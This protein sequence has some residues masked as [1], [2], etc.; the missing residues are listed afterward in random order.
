MSVFFVFRNEIYAGVILRNDI[1]TVYYDESGL[2]VINYGYKKGV[3][4]G[5]HINPLAVGDA[6]EKYYFQ[7]VGGNATA[8]PLLMNVISWLMNNCRTATVAIHNE[9]KQVCQWVYNFSIWNIPAGWT[10]SM[11]DAQILHVFAL[12]YSY[13]KNDTYLSIS[14]RII[15]GFEIPIY[16]G[17]NRLVLD[18][19]T[20]WYPEVIVAPDIDSS[21]VTPLILNG[22]LYALEDLFLSYLLLNQSRVQDIF[23]TGIASARA[24][25]HKYELPRNWTYYKLHPQAIASEQYHRVHVK[26]TEILYDITNDSL[27]YTYHLRWSNFTKYPEP[28]LSEMLNTAGRYL[29]YGSLVLLLAF[30]SILSL[31]VLQITVRRRLKRRRLR[32][33]LL[34]FL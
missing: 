22:F 30:V 15:N 32:V 1:S 12:A 18:D 26:L 21:F 9:T 34:S 3:Y 13:Y 19:G 6:A 27:F 16:Q 10:S 23:Q 2:P 29:F 5:P 8:E 7:M 25:L 33:K 20:V 11:A 17:G 14:D 28:S 4:V 24:N 31:D